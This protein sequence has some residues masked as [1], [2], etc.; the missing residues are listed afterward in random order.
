MRVLTGA[1]MDEPPPQSALLPALV[2]VGLV[3]AGL[4]VWWLFPVFQGWVA[5]QDC[6]AVGRTNCG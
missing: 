3:A 4:L 1:G 5:H 2:L 6:V